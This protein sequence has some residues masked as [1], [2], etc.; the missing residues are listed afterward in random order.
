METMVS[1][2]QPQWQCQMA[3]A[4]GQSFFSMPVHCQMAQMENTTISLREILESYENVPGSA[5]TDLA[6]GAATLESLRGTSSVSGALLADSTTSTDK[7]DDPKTDGDGGLPA[8]SVP[9]SDGGDPDVDLENNIVTVRA[10]LGM[11]EVDGWVDVSRGT[12]MANP[13]PPA[14]QMTASVPPECEKDL[15][16]VNRL[17]KVKALMK[18]P[19]VDVNLIK[20]KLASTYFGKQNTPTLSVE[21]Y[22][23]KAQP[24]LTGALTVIFQGKG[25]IYQRGGEAG[26]SPKLKLHEVSHLAYPVGPDLDVSLADLLGVKYHMGLN[27]EQTGRNASH[28]LSTYFNSDCFTRNITR[29]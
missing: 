1:A 26:M 27:A 6:A 5:V 23:K 11:S 20:D 16:K 15:A 13:T 8:A 2:D 18:S 21:E 12:P 4:M 9:T 17:G 10:G 7:P 19:V 3:D 22:F 24:S 29:R 14:T 28:A 25:A